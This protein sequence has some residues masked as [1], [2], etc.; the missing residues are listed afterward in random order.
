MGLFELAT[1][2]FS[3]DTTGSQGSAAKPERDLIRLLVFIWAMVL[4]GLLGLC[5]PAVAH[6]LQQRYVDAFVAL[7]SGAFLAG[8][9]TAL[10]SFIGFLFGVPRS[11]EPQKQGDAMLSHEPNSYLPNTNLEQ[12]SDWLTKIM[13]GVGLVEIRSVLNWFSEVG[14]AAGSAIWPDAPGRIIAT[15]I[16]VHYVLMGFFQGFLVAYLYLPK[17]FENARQVR[18]NVPVA[19]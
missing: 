12:I 5:I 6:A 7:G 15:S 17:A 8:A 11:R 16:L 10:G 13:V 19:P 1:R 14:A 18:E 9:A 3:A 2:I 4:T